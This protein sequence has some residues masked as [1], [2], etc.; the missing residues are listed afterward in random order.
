MTLSL[1]VDLGSGPEPAN[2]FG[3]KNVIGIDS[4][5][6]G[7]KVRQCWVGLDPLPLGD[8][9]ANVVTAFD[10]I[11]H[12]PRALWVD[13]RLV[14]PFVEAMNEVW[15]VLKDG[16]LFYAR[17]PAYPHPEAFQDPTHLNII[18]DT[19][20]SC[21][22]RRPQLDGSEIDPWGISLGQRYGFKGRFLLLSQCWEG[23]HLVWRMQAE[24]RIEKMSES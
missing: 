1:A 2:P 10:F 14:N 3:C 4:C 7:E 16:G 9:V 23:S 20:V 18:T 12:L 21:F 24:K 8:S 5:A 22:A 6:F 17:T 19:T 13:G 11:E 15:R